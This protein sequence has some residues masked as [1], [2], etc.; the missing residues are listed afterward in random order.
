VLAEAVRQLLH[1]GETRAR[2]GQ[3]ARATAVRRFDVARLGPQLLAVY[4]DAIPKLRRSFLAAS[5]LPQQNR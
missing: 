4:Q 2:L 5:S 3:N 1:D